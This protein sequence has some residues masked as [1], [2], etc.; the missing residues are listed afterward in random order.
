MMV[1]I[2]KVNVV[3]VLSARLGILLFFYILAITT[4]RVRQRLFWLLE[5]KPGSGQL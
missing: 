1:F 2:E 4:M 5:M 3:R